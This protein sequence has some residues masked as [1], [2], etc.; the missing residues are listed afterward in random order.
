MRGSAV[1]SALALVIG[2]AVPALAQEAPSAGAPA[3]GAK[4]EHL[5]PTSPFR[6]L[7][8]APEGVK[9]VSPGALL[10]ASF[11]RNF[12]GKVSRAEITS[13][14]PGVFAVVD[15]NKDGKITGFEQTDWAASVGSQGEIL[16]NATMFDTNLDRVVTPDEFAKGLLRLADEVMGPATAE[17]AFTDLMKPLTAPQPDDPRGSSPAVIGRPAGNQVSPTVVGN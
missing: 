10:L 13:A 4:V 16:G 8:H 2:C 9:R 6:G 15:A 14:A 7:G 5:D 12:D 11:D 17:I 3:A 1:A